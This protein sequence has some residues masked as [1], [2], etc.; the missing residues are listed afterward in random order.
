MLGFDALGR[1]ALGQVVDQA[2]NAN[3][4]L[5]G[6]VGAGAAGVFGKIVSPATLT[7]VSGTG[8]AGTFAGVPTVAKLIPGVSGTGFAGTFIPW[9]QVVIPGAGGTGAA[10]SLASS[11][12]HGVPG[13]AATGFAGVFTP[14]VQAFFQGVGATGFAGSMIPANPAGNP[15]GV[16]G[17]GLAGN[18]TVIISGGGG[19]SGA[20]GDG[21]KPRRR[22]G[23]TGLEPIAKRPPRPAPELKRPE[24]PP[25]PVIEVP[26]APFE[27]PAE[28][29]FAEPP[30]GLMALRMQILDAQDAA[31]INRL[32]RDMDMD[33]QDLSDIADI[34]ALVDTLT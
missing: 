33:E 2:V 23:R 28:E 11:E 4:N 13:V 9:V 3:G 17:I 26:L 30:D 34:L 31:D 18:I 24:L 7:G 1:L 6:V 32:L 22:R 15:Q 21:D 5:T 10:G 14:W 8:A 25:V 20:A 19:S 12:F 27:L 16:Q 29:K